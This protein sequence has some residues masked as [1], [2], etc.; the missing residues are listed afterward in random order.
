[1]IEKRFRYV[2]AT[3]EVDEHIIDY[4][5][6]PHFEYYTLKGATDKLN[7][8][9]E[10]NKDNKAMIEFLSTENTQ[11]MNELKTRTQIQH[12]LEYENEQLKQE[13][14]DSECECIEVHYHDNEVR[15]DNKI[16]E[17]KIE[18]KE[19]FGRDFE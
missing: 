12:Q 18:F 17:L 9:A 11:I 8:L 1:M 15:R 13:L 10:E 7:E 5:T 6:E 14:F 19:R 16:E 2:D 4:G 3:D